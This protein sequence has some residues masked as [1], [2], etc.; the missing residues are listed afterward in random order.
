MTLPDLNITDS[1]EAVLSGRR[2][3]FRLL[4]RAVLP[5]SK[6]HIRIRH[7]ISEGFIVSTRRA[8]YQVKVEVPHVSHHI[9]SHYGM[10]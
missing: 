8:K 1:S 6:A 4:V 9:S 10:V 3:P 2:P 5:P 7:A